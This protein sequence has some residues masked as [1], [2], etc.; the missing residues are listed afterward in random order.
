MQGL[1]QLELLA[2]WQSGLLSTH[3]EILVQL[4]PEHPK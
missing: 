4:P 2:A 1:L 3:R